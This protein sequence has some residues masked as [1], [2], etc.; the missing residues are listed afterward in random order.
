MKIAKN[1]FFISLVF[2]VFLGT[3]CMKVQ[4]ITTAEFSKNITI[5]VLLPLSEKKSD[6]GKTLLS[7]LTLA[8]QELNKKGGI[9]NQ[10][11]TLLINDTKCDPLLA[12]QEAEELSKMQV[13]AIIGG[14]CD[15]ETDAI[16][17]TAEQK[18]IVF[19]T[20]VSSID[21]LTDY[22]YTFR[23]VPANT[24]ESENAAGFAF[25]V[26]KITKA[27]VIF[28]DARTSAEKEKSF[29]HYFEGIG[30]TV[31]SE[32]IFQK[33]TTNVQSQIARIKLSKS[34][35]IYI[36]SS[37]NTEL[38]MIA[39]ELRKQKIP[40]TILVGNNILT[41]TFAEENVNMTNN[42]YA[43]RIAFSKENEQTKKVLDSYTELTHEENRFPFWTATTYDSMQLLSKAINEVGTKPRDI[44]NYFYIFEHQKLA[45]GTYSIDG[46]GNAEMQY[47]MLK[48]KN[49]TL[50]KEK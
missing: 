49:G 19:I 45:A 3:A 31:I 1:L 26:L 9:H 36:L 46:N 2:L 6:L 14:V 13:I 21:S 25:N 20:P 41:E 27:A 48:V 47:E 32:E 30:G 12:K 40:A 16:A 38:A 37:K 8:V 50:R 4:E 29:V 44:K 23:T 11:I 42:F 33:N 43:I 28:E 18:R 7:T 35:F 10:S 22:E 34:P 39:D 5:G 15:E 17:I 24:A